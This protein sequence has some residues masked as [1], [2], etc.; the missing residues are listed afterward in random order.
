LPT[1]KVV[2]EKRINALQEKLT[3]ALENKDITFFNEVAANMAQ[4]LEL[5]PEDLAGALLCL[6]QQQSPIKVEEVK[7]QPRERNER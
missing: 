6:A 4:K 1:A 5:A 2:E 7:I 3:L